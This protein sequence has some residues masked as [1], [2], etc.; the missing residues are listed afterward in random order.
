MP[1]YTHDDPEYEGGE[2]TPT[3]WGLLL[4]GIGAALLLWSL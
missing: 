2:W 3:H 4:L 1:N